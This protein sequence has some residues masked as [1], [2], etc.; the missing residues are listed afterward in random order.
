MEVGFKGTFE[1]VVDDEE[2][3]GGAEQ[4]EEGGEGEAEPMVD[5]P[6][7]EPHVPAA[8]PARGLGRESGGGRDG[9]QDQ[10][11][12]RQRRLSVRPRPE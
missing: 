11:S 1:L 5:A 4:D 12:R 9:R 7:H 6:D 3:A 10:K 2:G 8:E